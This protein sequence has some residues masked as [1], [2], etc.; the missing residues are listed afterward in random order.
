MELKNIILFKQ[1]LL[2]LLLI[3]SAITLYKVYLPERIRKLKD[4]T[5]QLMGQRLKKTKLDYF[6]YDRLNR[7]LSQNGIDFMFEHKINPVTFVFI[8]TALSL[9]FLAVAFKLG[10]EWSL[11]FGVLGIFIGFFFPDLI[12]KIS[13]D[14]DNETM[15]NDI[16]E[17][18][19]TLKIQT[20][21]GVFLTYSLSECY[22]AVNS[23]RL[24]MALLELNNK[25]LAKKDVETALDEFNM[26]FDNRYL[27]TFCIVLKQSLQSG[28]SVQ[29]LAD[30]SVQMTDIQRGINLKEKEKLDRRIQI[31]QLLIFLGLIAICLYGLGVEV[32]DSLLQF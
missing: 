26:Q 18:Y 5:S 31:L 19:D 16:K 4:S 7:Y 22:L 17:I 28:Q 11:I 3:L 12:I 13:N 23:R 2:V 24:K 8:K 25:I 10:G 30:L 6:N 21:A 15:M 1:V 32:M 27:D 14:S 20:K 9:L 29:I